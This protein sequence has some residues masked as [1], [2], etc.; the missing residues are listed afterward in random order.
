M[1]D[2]TV[3]RVRR[4]SLAVM[5]ACLVLGAALVGNYEI[6]L[7]TALALGVVMVGCWAIMSEVANHV[8]REGARRASNARAA[9]LEGARLTAS[10]MQDQI[11]NKL[12]LTVG[13]SEFLATDE[14]LP[15][16]LRELAQKALTGARAA[17]ATMSELKR[18]TAADSANNPAFL[19][20]GLHAEETEDIEHG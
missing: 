20:T 9:R 1:P 19:E 11:A 10:A 15:D 6:D 8:R 4:L 7:R 18:V 13:Y 5:V 17:A 3:R 2:K 12:S 16:D 14:R